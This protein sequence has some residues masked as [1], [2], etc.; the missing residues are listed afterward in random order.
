MCGADRLTALG[1]LPA[2]KELLGRQ[3]LPQSKAPW[4]YT[5]NPHY[6]NTIHPNSV[7]EGKRRLETS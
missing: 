4:R 3:Y 7:I 5:R 1:P 6:E 2:N